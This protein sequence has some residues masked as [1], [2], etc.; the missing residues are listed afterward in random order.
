[1]SWLVITWF[2]AFGWVPVQNE[3][4]G[5]V[6]L[7][8]ISGEIV[9]SAQ[10]GV[11]FKAIDKLSVFGDVETFMGTVDAF[12]GGG[13][14]VPYRADYTFGVSFEFNEHVSVIA[15]HECDHMIDRRPEDGYESSETKIIAKITG[16]SRF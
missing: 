13:V 14:F 11:S 8:I 3:A 16:K 2:L 9:T 10:I 15:T 1:M 12:S 6:S 7:K 4:V 5:P